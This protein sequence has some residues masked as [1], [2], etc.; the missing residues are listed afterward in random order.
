MKKRARPIFDDLTWQANEYRIVLASDR[1][2]TLRER[3]TTR[4]NSLLSGAPFDLWADSIPPIG[5]SECGQPGDRCRVLGGVSIPLR[6]L[7]L[8]S[9][10][11]GGC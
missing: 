9:R 4:S 10:V 1:Y 7:E 8:A 3:R 6:R 2:S 11:E 5:C